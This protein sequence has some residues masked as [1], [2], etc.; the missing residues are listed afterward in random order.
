MQNTATNTYK[1]TTAHAMDVETRANCASTVCT[2][3]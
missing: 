2:V 3:P 1:C